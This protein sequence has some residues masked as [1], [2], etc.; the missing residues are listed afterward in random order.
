M[1]MLVTSHE[2]H[3]KRVPIMSS[4]QARNHGAHQAVIHHK[5][6]SNIYWKRQ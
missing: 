3:S 5:K 6:F 1:P 2:L 4:E